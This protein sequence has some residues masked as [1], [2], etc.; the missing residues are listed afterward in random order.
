[1]ERAT[2][3]SAK[4]WKTTAGQRQDSET[5]EEV[6]GHKRLGH[7]VCGSMFSYVWVCV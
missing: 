1:M 2:K 3:L 6:L 4:E 7:T 5:L